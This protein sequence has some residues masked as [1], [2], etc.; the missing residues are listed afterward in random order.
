[1]GSTTHPPTFFSNEQSSTYYYSMNQNT[2][3]HYNTTDSFKFNLRNRLDV[4]TIYFDG[5]TIY[6]NDAAMK[7]FTPVTYTSLNRLVLFRNRLDAT[8]EY[9]R[10]SSFRL[11]SFKFFDGEKVVHDLVPC[12]R[13]ED[14]VIGVYDLIDKAFYTNQG[15]GEFNKGQ[16][17]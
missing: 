7:T 8:G 12:Y 13:K 4:D 16:N 6:Y 15:K 1:M 14:N 11:H 2:F 3:N 9:K 5:Q 10:Y 17:I